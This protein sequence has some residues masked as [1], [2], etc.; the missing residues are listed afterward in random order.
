MFFESAFKWLENLKF[1]NFVIINFSDKITISNGSE[2]EEV[3]CM[4]LLIEH[5]QFVYEIVAL[6]P[7]ASKRG[8]HK[9]LNVQ[10]LSK[11]IKSY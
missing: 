5:K 1:S 8:R 6:K 4:P 11:T 2:L 7:S 3:F 10:I 9:G